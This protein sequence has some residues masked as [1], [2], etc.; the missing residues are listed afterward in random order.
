[1]FNVFGRDEAY[2]VDM[3][4]ACGHELAQVVHFGFGGDYFRQ[5]LPGIAGA[6]DELYGVGHLAGFVLFLVGDRGKQEGE[7]E[8]HSEN[9]K[10]TESFIVRDA[11][12]KHIFEL[13]MPG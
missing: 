1:L 11:S 8:K 2:G 10:S 4:K 5:A 7:E 12:S 6:F 9:S 3:L 13:H